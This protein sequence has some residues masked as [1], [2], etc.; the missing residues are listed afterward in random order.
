MINDV[1]THVRHLVNSF[2]VTVRIPPEILTMI[3]SYLATEEDAFSAAQVCHHWRGVLVSSPSL[4]T[5]FPCR[6]VPRT[7]ISLERCKS[8]PIQLD[9]HRESSSVALE[10]VL[11]HG[12]RIASLTIHHRLDQIPLL[13]QL[14]T[15]SR[16]SVEQ[17]H[18]FCQKR[19][20]WKPNERT[21]HE[22][23]QDLP[24][25]RQLFVRRYSIPIH[26]LAAPNLVHLVLE[27]AGHHRNITVQSVLD[28]L[29]RCPLLETLF[30]SLFHVGRDPTR[31]H[32]P[33]SL[34]HLRSIELGP[35]EV[36]SGLTTHLQFPPNVAV[37]FRMLFAA[38][39]CGNT[40]PAVMATMQHVLRRID[41]RCITLAVPLNPTGDAGLLVRFDGLCG[42]LEITTYAVDT[43]RKTRSVFF[44][45]KGVLFSHSP[46][47][48][49]VREL[50]IVGCPFGGDQGLLC[51]SAAMPN[52]VSISFFHCKELHAFGLLTPAN[53]SLPP[54][55][56][57]EQI[58]VLGPDSGLREMVKTRRDCGVPL[59]T[60]V[61][62]RGS[63]S[64]C[65]HLEDYTALEDFVD[66]L[67]IGCPTEILEWGTENEILNIWSTI[68]IP[69]PVSP[70]E[71]MVLG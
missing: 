37:G 31:D 61:V 36:R 28:A 27:E 11:L 42:S 5:R 70:L 58:M 23:W 17:L 12:D 45:P 13:H 2:H 49:N 32:S 34:P 66:D 19:S 7:I 38:D 53:P 57:V 4:W 60:L 20:G 18:I 3:C 55:P 44:G 16:P 30:I 67:R 24:R 35:D 50:H 33:V 59:K 15:S 41:I 51:A 54:F 62:G 8:M 71:L 69:C 52:L 63:G 21:A 1:V 14:F 6:H 29:H 10:K 26:Q 46:N 43:W 64:E 40:P 9:F 25:L 65:D 68:E 39:V 22:I 56:H 48:E 47:I